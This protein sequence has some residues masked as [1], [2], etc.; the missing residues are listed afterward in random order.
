MIKEHGILTRD[1]LNSR[2]LSPPMQ[3]ALFEIEGGKFLETSKLYVLHD[4]VFHWYTMGIIKPTI[5]WKQSPYEKIGRIEV[6][7]TAVRIAWSG[8]TVYPVLDNVKRDETHRF[9][10]TLLAFQQAGKIPSSLVIVSL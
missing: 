7:K 9:V 1:E 8:S 4:G 3:K 5:F 6:D 10:Q 2:L